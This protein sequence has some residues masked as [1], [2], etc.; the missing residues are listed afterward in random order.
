MSTREDLLDA[1]ITLFAQRGF[2]GVSIQ[3]VADQVNITKQ[4]LL[5]HFSN[6]KK[7]YAAVLLKAAAELEHFVERTNETNSNPRQA[8]SEIFS[9][10]RTAE[11]PMLEMVVLLLRELLDNHHRAATAQHWFLRP[12]L[13]A[14]TAVVAAAQ[15]PGQ[16]PQV[17]P[18][19]LTYHLLGAT[20]Y[21]LISKPTLKR[22]Y[23]T[24]EYRA[25][26]QA[27]D[28]LIEQ[29]IWPH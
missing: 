2:D 23:S 19:A 11:G 21:F 6:K 4:G 18:L 7:L 14:L 16:L 22:L 26:E 27:H 29:I 28:Q 20:Q 9:E 25:L 8:L 3:H 5:H 17:Q 12:F 24:S 10:L 13:D 15:T 1:A